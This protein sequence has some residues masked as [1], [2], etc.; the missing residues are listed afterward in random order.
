MR[1]EVQGMNA[2]FEAR[3]DTRLQTYESGQAVTKQIIETQL[4]QSMRRYND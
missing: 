2:A 4:E 1:K 3:I